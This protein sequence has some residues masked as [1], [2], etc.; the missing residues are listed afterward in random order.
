MESR[1]SPQL[2]PALSS[3]PLLV[4]RGT[5]ALVEGSF[6]I[7][8]S[9]EIECEVRGELNVGGTL[10]IGEKGKVSADVTTVNA[11]I[12]GHYTGKMTASGSIEIAAS[13]R[14]NG[15]LASNELVIAKGG[16]FTGSVARTGESAEAESSATA[17]TAS[18]QRPKQTEQPSQ[19]RAASP[20]NGSTSNQS[21]TP[22]M[23]AQLG[24]MPRSSTP[25][26][27]DVATTELER[28]AAKDRQRSQEVPLA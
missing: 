10:V 19:D 1:Q 21:K 6:D 15:T 25:A 2:D 16:V 11:V 17:D 3:T 18:T 4:V 13:G 9:I 27:A 20:R 5:G 24:D 14:A 7:E 26:L 12:L 28:N 8:D 22:R 23:P